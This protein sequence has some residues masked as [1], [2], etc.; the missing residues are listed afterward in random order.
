MRMA[1]H[2]S[3]MKKAYH[4]SFVFDENDTPLVNFPKVANGTLTYVSG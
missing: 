4:L 2:F 1:Y 3:S